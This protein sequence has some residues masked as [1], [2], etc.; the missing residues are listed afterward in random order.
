LIRQPLRLLERFPQQ[1]FDL[2]VQAAQIVVCP[3]LNRV[4]DI[5]IYPQ[6]KRFPIRH[7]PP[8]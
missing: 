6:E 2:T 4:K 5:S 3:T 1:E 8:Q 7:V